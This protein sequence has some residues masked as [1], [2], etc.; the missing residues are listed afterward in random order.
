LLLY[1]FFYFAIDISVAPQTFHS[2]SNDERTVTILLLRSLL[3]M[4]DN[5]P[6]P[7]FQ[8]LFDNRSATTMTTMTAMTMTVMTT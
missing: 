4:T 6:F 2:L 1:H 8:L 7:S 3:A 5:L